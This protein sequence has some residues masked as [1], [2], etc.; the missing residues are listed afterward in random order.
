ML[1]CVSEIEIEPQWQLHMWPVM[2]C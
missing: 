2:L 1:V